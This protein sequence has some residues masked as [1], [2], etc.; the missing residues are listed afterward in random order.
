MSQEKVWDQEYRESTFLT[1]DN[2]PQKDVVRFMQF[3]KKARK[4]SINEENGG[5]ICVLDLGSGTGRNSFYLSELGAVVTGIEISQT[6]IALAKQNGQNAGL[7]IQYIHHSM[8]DVFPF[9]ENRFDI[10]LDITSSNS[11][12]LSERGTYLSETHR[13][14][15]DGAYFFV[16]ALCK[17]GDE[18]AKKLLKEVPGSERDTYIMPHTGIVE[19]VWSKEDFVS[20]YEKYFTILQLER[21]TT[22]TRMNNRVYKRNFWLCY[23]QKRPQA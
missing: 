13:V 15:K 11:L 2:V 9:Q 3:L 12:T 14:M 22:Y 7:S 5:D 8:G 23:M 4:L 21:K 19:R 1:K 17:D 20:T 16:K 6:A 10:V 18:N